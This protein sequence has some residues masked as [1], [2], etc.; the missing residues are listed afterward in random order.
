MKNTNT[1]K[2]KQTV[3]TYLCNA[4][5]LQ[6]SERDVAKYLFQRFESEYNHGSNRKCIPNN[7]Q[8]IAEWLSGLA[9]D[10]DF[11]N[12]DIIERAKEWHSVDG[13]DEAM[14]EKITNNW[15]NFLAIKLNQLWSKHDCVL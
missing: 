13:F 7:Q 3:F 8:R 12:H 9:I 15:F 1:N 2:F 4:A 5:E 10:I 11:T 6:G 14:V